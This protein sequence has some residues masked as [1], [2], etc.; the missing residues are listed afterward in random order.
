MTATLTIDLFISVDGC[1]GTETLPGYFGYLGPELDAWIADESAKP[2]VALMGRKTY[3]VLS[4]LPDEAKDEGHKIMT[5]RETV[6]FSRTLSDVEWPNARLCNS[7]VVQ[8]TRRLKQ[9]TDL[10]LRTMGSLSICRQLIGSGL[11]DRIR[12]MTFPLFAGD[13]ATEW[14]FSDF[15]SAEL[16][17]VGHRTLDGRLLLIE[18][19]PTGVDIPRM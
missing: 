4:G 18:Y 13:A 3:E 19:R 2:Q 11:A 7:D 8:E 10:P 5:E 6:V 9:E 12:L 14:A 15:A 16:A 17:L 1:A